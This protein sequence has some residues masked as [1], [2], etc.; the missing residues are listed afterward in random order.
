[1]KTEIIK[2]KGDW[3]EVVNDCR[4]TV[5][6]PELGREPSTDFKKKIL[7]A[8]HDPIRDIEIKF[9]WR[10]IPYWIAMHWKTHIWRSRTN[11]Q[12][13][14]RQDLYDRGKA[15]QDT[16]V[17][18]IGD[19]NA[20]HLI[21]TMRKRLCYMAAPETRAYAEDLKRA[22]REVE[23]ELSDVLV[24]NCVYRCGCPECGGCGAFHRMLV[25][26]LAITSTYIQLRYDA[27]NRMFYGEE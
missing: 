20:Q 1:M 3:P 11:T 10:N 19:P 14:D 8:E 16:P 13:N 7:I 23:P 15:P 24:P 12:R 5:A 26:D 17:D 2:V 22:L 21:D 25:S 6:K 4:A 18:F 9:R 27:Y